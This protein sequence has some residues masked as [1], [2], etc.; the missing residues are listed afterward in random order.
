MSGGSLMLGLLDRA[1]KMLIA[2]G[3]RLHTVGEY[4]VRSTVVAVAHGIQAG[5]VIV[6]KPEN[7]INT[8]P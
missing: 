8:G 5:C 2:N 4:V 1:I 7:K 3:D 6:S